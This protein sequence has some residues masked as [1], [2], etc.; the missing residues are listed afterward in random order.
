M[1]RVPLPLEPNLSGLQFS[2][3]DTRAL[4]ELLI[5]VTVGAVTDADRKFAHLLI[6]RYGYFLAEL[7]RE[8][9]PQPQRRST[10]SPRPDQRQAPLLNRRKKKG[11]KR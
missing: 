8:Q 10:S 7:E 9:P 3:A 4:M 11:G 1:K 5:G 2:P 6:L